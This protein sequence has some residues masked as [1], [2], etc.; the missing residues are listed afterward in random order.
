MIGIVI[1]W[2]VHPWVTETRSGYKNWL[3]LV[4][5]TMR[6][7]NATDL[8]IIGEFPYVYDPAPE[9]LKVHNY[10]TLEAVL[11]AYSETQVVVFDNVSEA[12]PLNAFPHPRDVDVLYLIGSDYGDQDYGTLDQRYE[13]FQVVKIEV[14][15]K[16]E[17]LLWTPVVIGIALYDRFRKG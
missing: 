6:T 16:G 12:I 13:R 1:Y 11:D 10:Q 14:R 7:F 3:N 2:D 15:T 5:Y 17:M 8:F 9:E 4:S